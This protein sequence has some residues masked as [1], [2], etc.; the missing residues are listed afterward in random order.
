MAPFRFW[1]EPRHEEVDQQPHLEHAVV[2]V[3][4]STSPSLN[5]RR[6][7]NLNMRKLIS[8]LMKHLVL[9]LSINLSSVNG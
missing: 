3:L 9:L 6:I 1:Q 8:N 7:K 5:E 4:L 2:V